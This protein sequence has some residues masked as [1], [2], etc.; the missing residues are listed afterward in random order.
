MTRYA[1]IDSYSVRTATMQAWSVGELEPSGEL[2]ANHRQYRRA[3]IPGMIH[4][5]YLI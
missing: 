5:Y 4:A 2:V 3:S 1:V